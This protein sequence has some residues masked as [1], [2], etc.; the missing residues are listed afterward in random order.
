MENNYIYSDNYYQI[1]NKFYPNIFNPNTFSNNI[2]EINDNQNNFSTPT[3][4]REVKKKKNDNFLL[5]EVRQ[6]LNKIYEEIQQLNQLAIIENKRSHSLN[7]KK[8]KSNYKSH[9][10]TLPNNYNLNNKTLNDKIDNQEK[11]NINVNLKDLNVND[12]CIDS[13]IKYY[14]GNNFY[15]NNKFGQS[16]KFNINSQSTQIK[17]KSDNYYEYYNENLIKDHKLNNDK[18]NNINYRQYSSNINNRRKN[19]IKIN[20]NNRYNYFINGNNI[21]SQPVIINNKELFEENKKLKLYIKK[22]NANK[23]N[24]LKKQIQEIESWKNDYD[25]IY[26]EKISLT[27]NFENLKE[28]NKILNDKFK[29]IEGRNEEIKL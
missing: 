15:I 25:K 21:N 28:E 19:P 27:K 8:I 20:N 29:S 12:Y 6:D 23:S 14:T 5:Y 16:D 3:K 18:N 2:L 26:K 13:D 24:D 7:P 4:K 22:I 1:N 9:K 17:N 10:N 11:K